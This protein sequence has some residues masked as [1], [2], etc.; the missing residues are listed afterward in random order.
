MGLFQTLVTSRGDLVR[1]SKVLDMRAT[2]Y[3]ASFEDTGETPQSS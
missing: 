3:T 2:A 1:Y